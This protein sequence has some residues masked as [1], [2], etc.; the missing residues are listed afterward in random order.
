M[1]AAF[2][3]AIKEGKNTIERIDND[4]GYNKENCKFADK[5][6]QANNRRNNVFYDFEGERLTLAQICRRR[7]V[8]YKKTWKRINMLSWPLE[9]ALMEN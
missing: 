7:G 4:G 6:E 2:L 8:N 9:N 1:L 5:I 3:E